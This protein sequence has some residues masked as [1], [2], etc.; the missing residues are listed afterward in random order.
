ME[1]EFVTFMITTADGKEVELAVVDEFEF[2]HKNYAVAALV[3]NDEISGEGRFIYRMVEK[4]DDISFEKIRN[5]V[6]YQKIAEAYM[7]MEEE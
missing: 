1:Q 2:E 3:E 5:M 7:E 6:D 4:D